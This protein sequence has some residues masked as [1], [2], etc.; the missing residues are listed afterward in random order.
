MDDNPYK[1][2]DVGAPPVAGPGDSLSTERLRRYLVPAMIATPFA[3]G[4]AHFGGLA[5]YYV[6]APEKA[7]ARADHPYVSGYGAACAGFLA[8]AM[9]VFVVTLAIQRLVARAPRSERSRVA[10]YS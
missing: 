4:A 3:I 6:F 2:P 7:A 9:F 10:N 8:C 5:L 1:P